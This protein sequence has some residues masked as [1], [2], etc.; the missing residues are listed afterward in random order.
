MKNYITIYLS[1]SFIIINSVP[2]VVLILFIKKPSSRIRFYIDYRKFNI[3]TKKDAYLIPFIK[4]TLVALN[5]TIIISKLDIRHT[6]NRI[7]FK[8]T[9]NENLIIFKISIGIFKYLIVLFGFAN[10]PIVF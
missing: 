7:R 1:K 8:T 10:K 5:R 6:F 3:I 2:H 9:T 4:E